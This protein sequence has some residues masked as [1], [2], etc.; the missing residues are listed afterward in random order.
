MA[1]KESSKAS[2]GNLTEAQAK[3][4][5]ARLEA[6]IAA[7]DRRYYDEDAPTVSDLGLKPRVLGFG[8]R[9]GEVTHRSFG[10]FFNCHPAGNPLFRVRPQLDTQTS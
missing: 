5:H 1:V 10:A 9:F 4:E 8:L 2:V 7:H 6:E 3:A